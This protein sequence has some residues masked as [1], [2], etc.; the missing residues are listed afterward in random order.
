MRK[1]KSAKLQRGIAVTEAER[2]I[3]SAIL[4]AEVL[5]TCANFQ[6][7]GSVSRSAS[8]SRTPNPAPET[9]NLKTEVEPTGAN[10]ENGGEKPCAHHIG[11]DFVPL[12]LHKNPFSVDSVYSCSKTISEF[13][14]SQCDSPRAAARSA[15]LHL[16][17]A[18]R[19]QG[20]RG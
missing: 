4:S 3:Y 16:V 17:A 7:R 18:V 10:G 6:D 14:F 9:F 1:R 11:K 15:A 19:R 13:G 8:T 2:G 20:F 5:F 12:C